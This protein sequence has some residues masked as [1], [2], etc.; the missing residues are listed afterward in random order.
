[1]S[2]TQSAAEI[3]R[4][5]LADFEGWVVDDGVPR[6]R[7]FGDPGWW[8]DVLALTWDFRSLSGEGIEELRKAARG[9]R[10]GGLRLGTDVPLHLA[11]GGTSLMVQFE[12]TSDHG[13]GRGIAHLVRTDA[14]WRA[15]VLFT[16]LDE[17][18]GRREAIGADRPH[19]A[20]TSTLEPTWGE[21]RA[22]AAEFADGEPDVVIVGAGHSGLSLAARLE[23]VGV[24]ALVV[25]R[26]ARV[27]DSWRNRYASLVLHD[28]T[29]YNH[30]PYLPFPTT[31]PR[32]TPK[33][34]MGDWLELYATALDL[35]VWT[36][37]TVRHAELPDADG[38]WSVEVSRGD[39]VRTLRPAH[40]VVATGLS[41][42]RPFLP[43]LTGVEEFGGPVQHSSLFRTGAGAAG[44]RVLVVGSGNSGH[45][46]AQDL[47]EHGAEVTL[48]QRSPSHVVA[49]DTMLAMTT[50]LFGED[51]PPTE[52]ADLISWSMP[53][54][55]AG[56]R[57][58]A[59]TAAAA[60]TDAALLDGLRAAGFGL[61]DGPEGRGMSALFMERNGGYYI[62]VGCSRLIVDGTIA[63]K[64][65]VGIE[66]LEPGMVVFTDGDARGFD[67]IW[68]ATGFDGIRDTARD[69]LGPEAVA[70]AGPVWGLDEEGELRSVWRASGQPGL[71]FMGGNLSYARAGSKYLAL[72]ITAEVAGVR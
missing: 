15:A 59:V 45:D 49:G 32:F 42:N 61:T 51:G 63:V 56:D 53:F 39:A 28:P 6:E 24:R 13:A 68:L 5:W 2:E 27:G 29:T 69:I 50:Q 17:V 12:L 60:A 36:E 47:A 18:A 66:R 25:E 65:G 33:D 64:H 62:D 21:Q 22:R 41:G 44:S 31:W 57:Q 48:L 4:Q 9:V 19:G 37:A 8:R 23:R 30:L 67:A 40:V 10:F 38:R 34:K 43:E 3:A 26:A 1:M 46:L 71:W 35:N 11:A 54:S 16:Q 7:V 52:V 14:G 55:A 70:A 72:Q 58:R 20:H